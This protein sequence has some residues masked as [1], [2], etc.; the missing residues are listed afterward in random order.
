MDLGFFDVL[1]LVGWSISTVG[2]NHSLQ[3]SYFVFA[4]R[5]LAT[6]DSAIVSSSL[7][8]VVV[9]DTDLTVE[10][11]GQYFTTTGYRPRPVD[12]CGANCCPME[13]DGYM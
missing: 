7:A 9:L 5:C 8:M 6:V 12:G 1:Q 4:L 10:D 13:G 3:V 11:F 2:L